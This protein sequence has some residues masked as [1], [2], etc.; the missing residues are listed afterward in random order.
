M[1]AIGIAFDDINKD[2][3]GAFLTRL[4]V[5]VV[6]TWSAAAFRSSFTSHQFNILWVDRVALY[7]R[8]GWRC[9]GFAPLPGAGGRLPFSGFS[10]RCHN[11]TFFFANIPPQPIF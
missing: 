4:D 10:F 8:I 3:T 6:S 9:V 1:L 5:P 7:V 2:V 11:V